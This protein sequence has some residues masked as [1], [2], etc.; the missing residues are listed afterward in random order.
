MVSWVWI[1]VCLLIGGVIGM[2]LTALC[3]AG[4]KG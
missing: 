3:V 1:P 2:F 4:E